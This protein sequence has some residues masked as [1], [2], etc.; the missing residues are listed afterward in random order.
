MEISALSRCLFARD[1]A[2]LPQRVRHELKVAV[3]AR[4]FTTLHFSGYVLVVILHLL[5]FHIFLSFSF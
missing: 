4:E 3:C 5:L 1:L 2:A